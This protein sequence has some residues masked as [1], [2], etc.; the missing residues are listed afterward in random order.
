MNSPSGCNSLSVP[1]RERARAA[2]HFANVDTAHAIAGDALA[3]LGREQ[4]FTGYDSTRDKAT[5]VG[6]FVDGVLGGVRMMAAR[7]SG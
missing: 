5:V 2:S 1:A 4:V 3:A 7:A 6:L